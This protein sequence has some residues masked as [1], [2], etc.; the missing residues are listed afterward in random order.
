MKLITIYDHTG[1]IECEL[2]ANTYR[3]FGMQTVRLPVIKLEATVTPFEDGRGCTL[4]VHRFGKPW[5]P[6]NAT[7]AHSLP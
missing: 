4:E 6:L 1:I 7:L 5:G 3:R 2:F